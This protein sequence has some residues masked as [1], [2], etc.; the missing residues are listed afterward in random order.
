MAFVTPLS[1]GP[2]VIMVGNIHGYF[3]ISVGT[4]IHGYYLV[5]I[6][7]GQGSQS[8]HDSGQMPGFEDFCPVFA[9]ILIFA[10][11]FPVFSF[12]PETVNAIVSIKVNSEFNCPQALELFL[13]N[14]DLLKLAK[15]NQKYV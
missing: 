15:F 4:N 6:M 5:V 10:R 12:K 11:F 9:R 8:H 14:S 1:P 3:I 7:R 2:V 13:S